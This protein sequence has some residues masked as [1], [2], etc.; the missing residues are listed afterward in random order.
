MASM[1]SS[2]SSK[3][4]ACD[5][6]LVSL[7]RAS[8][9]SHSAIS[10]L[11]AHISEHGL[12]ETYDRSAQF[13]A[14]KDICRKDVNGYGPLVVDRQMAAQKGGYVTGTFQ[15]PLA[16]FAYH[17]QH[18]S[19]YARIVK[20]ASVEHPPSPG[21][22][23]RL[24]IYQDG[25]D[26]SDGL[27]KNHSRKS[28]V[29]YWAF[30]EFG[31]QVLAHEE[32]WLTICVSR[33]SQ[34]NQLA[35]TVS[36]LFQTVL[37]LFFG[38]THDIL[39]TGVHVTLYN[40]ESFHVFGKASILLADV[41]ALKECTYCKGHSGTI[42][43]P[44]CLNA[45]LHSA[46]DA[47]PL[48]LLTDE[49][50][51]ITNF[52]IMAFKELKL[53]TLR[54]ITRRNNADHAAWQA[55]RISKAAFEEAE[56]RRGW[57]WTPANIIL[58]DRFQLNVTKMIMFDWAHIYVHDGLGDVE[59][60]LAM[61]TLQKESK[62]NTSFAECGQVVSQFELPKSTPKLDHLFHD[63]KNRNNY[64]K[65]SFTCTG[66]QFL[67]LTPLLHYYFDKVV[68]PRGEQLEIV[69]SMLAVLSVIML[70]TSL[71]TGTISSEQLTEAILL[72]LHLFSVAWGDDYVRPKHHY[73]IHLGP[74]LRMFGFLLATFV[75]ERKH[76]LVTR[77]C[78]DRKNLSRWDMSAIEEITCHQ[79]WQLNLDFMQA[80]E[81][82]QPRGLMLIPLQEMF[83]GV[84][85][86]DMRVC[87]AIDC[88][89]GSCSSGDVVSFLQEGA[90]VG[91][92]LMSVAVK[93]GGSWKLESIIA[94]WKL[95]KALRAGAMW[96][97]F[98]IAG[99][100]VVK[101]PTDCIDTVLLWAPTPDNT[102]CNIYMPPEIRPV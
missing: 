90:Q 10:K 24:I 35:G 55:G 41:P 3:R 39:R 69:N 12:P 4:K 93:I 87:S 16:A 5:L 66:S 56:T 102:S 88:N 91:Q 70:L 42:C 79:I 92:L 30:A 80:C 1:A 2:S 46:K 68:K 52:D 85:A 9:A 62:Y 17:C 97:K 36:C 82:S 94:R 13:R 22:P 51:S 67:T 101:I 74:M 28:T 32:V 65:K 11:L 86:A 76:R 95:A 29:F 20:N 73:S 57:C 40:G 81:T 47:I 99:D 15:N 26:P 31:Q 61:S 21:S 63:D 48:H 18:S 64:R 89:K 6:E 78:R 14:R 25:V 83:P 96:A 23:W 8:Y 33:S 58:N 49:A 77:Y 19:Q 43:C 100:D 54:T 34:T 50:V 44:L 75:Q 60:G 59:F 45:V 27:A 53:D 84:P 38:E 7:G 71:N 37:E 98:M 72:H